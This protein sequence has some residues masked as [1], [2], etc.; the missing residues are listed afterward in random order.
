MKGN[1]RM[2]IRGMTG[3]EKEDKEG[4]IGQSHYPIFCIHVRMSATE[5]SVVKLT[6]TFRRVLIEPTVVNVWLCLFILNSWPYL[7]NSSGT[8]AV[9]PVSGV[10]HYETPIAVYLLNTLKSGCVFTNGVNS[11][12]TGCRCT[13]RQ[14]FLDS[15]PSS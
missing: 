4:R 2:R 1:T 3:T 15:M 7:N 13:H 10:I 5:L 9:K 12:C 6:T 8:I 11:A 14:R